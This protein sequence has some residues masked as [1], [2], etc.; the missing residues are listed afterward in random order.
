[1]QSGPCCADAIEQ[2]DML[3]FQ[4]LGSRYLEY[5]LGILPTLLLTLSGLR[6]SVYRSFDAVGSCG[7]SSSFG[8]AVGYIVALIVASLSI[9]FGG[10]WYGNDKINVVKKS[11]VL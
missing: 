7:Y 3:P 1:M 4:G 2:K 11:A 10:E 8:D 6:V 5:V 9:P